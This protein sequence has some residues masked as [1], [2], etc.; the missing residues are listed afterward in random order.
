MTHGDAK[1]P[2]NQQSNQL[3]T[4]AIRIPPVFLTPGRALPGANNPDSV[5]VPKY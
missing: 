1:F 3:R 5:N 4:E 2:R